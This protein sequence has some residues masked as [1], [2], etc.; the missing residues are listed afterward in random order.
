MQEKV[1]AELE[2]L[3]D[4]MEREVEEGKRVL[5]ELDEK[6]KAINAQID[7]AL[8]TPTVI[9]TITFRGRAKTLRGEQKDISNTFIGAAPAVNE[10]MDI[11]SEAETKLLVLQKRL[12]NQRS[13]KQWKHRSIQRRKSN[14]TENTETNGRAE[15]KPAGAEKSTEGQVIREPR[16]TSA[17]S[18][19]ELEQTSG[20]DE[21]VRTNA[22]HA[23][24]I[25]IQYS[26]HC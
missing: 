18:G 7:A 19:T 12:Q 25:G 4:E 13:T 24:R 17:A 9:P 16:E 11:P 15:K 1:E 26:G 22:E 8:N 21:A 14:V 6:R 2:R 5:M 3:E 23:S 10:S 20:A